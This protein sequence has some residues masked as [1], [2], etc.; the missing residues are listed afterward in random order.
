MRAGKSLRRLAAITFD[1]AYRGVFEYAWPVLA[2]LRPARHGVCRSTERAHRPPRPFGGI[3]RTPP[4]GPAAHRPRAGSAICVATGRLILQDLGVTPAPSRPPLTLPATWDVIRKAVRGGLDL[5]VHTAT[6][7]ALPR[8]NDAELRSEM[9][10]SRETLADRSGVL[11]EFFAYPY[12]LWDQRVR[13]AA[14]AAGYTMALTLDAHLTTHE[15]DP[16][17]APRVNIPAHISDAAFQ[18]WIAGW[19]PHRAVRG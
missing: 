7:R 2:E 15:T 9:V 5:G 11:A 16:W 14:R 8:L 19:S 4:G 6:H 10:D 13:D 12:G 17:A 18:T 1:D 3:T